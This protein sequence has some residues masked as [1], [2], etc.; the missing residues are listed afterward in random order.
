MGTHREWD[1][2]AD[3]YDQN[4]GEEGDPLNRTIIRPVVLEMLADTSQLTLL[5]VGC[6][7]GYLTAE[8][9]RRCRHVV[10]T[11]F[12]PS[13][14]TLCQ[15]KY[16]AITNLEF[17]E[18]DVAAAL[19]FGADAVDIVLCKMVLQYVPEI[20]TF[21]RESWRV[22]RRGGFLLLLV[23]HPFH[24]QFF[25]AQQVAGRPDSKYPGLADYFDARAHVKRSLWGKVDLT[26]YP[27]TV[28]DYL[29]PFLRA[30]LRLV[31]IRELPEEKAGV[32]VPRILVLKLGK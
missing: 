29:L 27:R 18:S 3:W 28:S 11:D 10:G 23:D 25:F 26:W 6:G 5:D 12:S 19:P 21:A 31:D 20:E 13:F 16:A 9:A 17:V 15:R 32:R 4:M 30:G 8:L 14:V 24:A 7:S 2:S 22:L 1:S